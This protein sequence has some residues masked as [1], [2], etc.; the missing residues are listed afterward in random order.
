MMILKQMKMVMFNII[1]RE[2]VKKKK[3]QIEE[4]NQEVVK[5]D[6]ERTL[7]PEKSKDMEKVQNQF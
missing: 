7:K 6:R 3:V 2:E 5:I 4:T 1:G